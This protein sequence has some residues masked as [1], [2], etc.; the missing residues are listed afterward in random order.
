MYLFLFKDG[1]VRQVADNLTVVD[2]LACKQGLLKIIRCVKQSFEKLLIC[3]DGLKW[4]RV[5][6]GNIFSIQDGRFHQ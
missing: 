1:S 4:K 5:K 3:D 2:I 6:K